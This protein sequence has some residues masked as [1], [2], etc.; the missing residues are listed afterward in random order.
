MEKFGKNLRNLG[1]AAVTALASLSAGAQEVKKTEK[2]IIVHDKN[3]P[4]LLEYQ[5]D[6]YLYN[7]YP[8]DT[9]MQINPITL[10]EEYG[11]PT[12]RTRPREVRY[13][14]LFS[15]IESRGITSAE[16][17]T[18]NNKV[19]VPKLDEGIIVETRPVYI[20]P[21]EPKGAGHVVGQERIVRSRETGKVIK[22]DKG[23]LD[24]S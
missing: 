24:Q 3:D 9:P 15:P 12:R 11:T 18:L 6:L 2:P 13:E 23:P 4:R 22:R 20:D 5:R 1:L 7:N 14:P 10:E 8:I 17:P 16:G 19:S 21:S